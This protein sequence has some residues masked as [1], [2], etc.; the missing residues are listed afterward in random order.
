MCIR[1]SFY[2]VRLTS[3]EAGDLDEVSEQIKDS[4]RRLIEQRNGQSLASAYLESLR[5]QLV[6]EIDLSSL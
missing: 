4:T 1:D 3:I 5:G 6:P 2:I